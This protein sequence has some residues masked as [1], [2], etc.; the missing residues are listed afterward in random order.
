MTQLTVVLWCSTDS[1]F[2][3]LHSAA[4]LELHC[5]CPKPNYLGVAL[6]KAQG[7]CNSCWVLLLLVMQAVYAQWWG[8]PYGRS[9]F[10]LRIMRSWHVHNHTQ[11]IFSISMMIE[12]VQ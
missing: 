6:Q 9:D 2:V 12:F 11:R 8:P 10:A 3:L 7:L 1:L 4:L 5:L